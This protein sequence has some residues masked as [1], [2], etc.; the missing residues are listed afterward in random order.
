MKPNTEDNFMSLN[1][2]HW[3]NLPRIDTSL[4]QKLGVLYPCDGPVRWH[5]FSKLPLESVRRS[6]HKERSEPCKSLLF[7]S[8][9]MCTRHIY[10]LIIC[11]EQ[12]FRF[13]FSFSTNGHLEDT[14]SLHGVVRK[15]RAG[16]VPEAHQDTDKLPSWNNSAFL[17]LV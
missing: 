9:S 10:S 1:S 6:R 17:Y 8:Y 3:N 16:Q 11:S 13:C 15:L 7:Y 14:S 2:F 5:S 12:S 4:I